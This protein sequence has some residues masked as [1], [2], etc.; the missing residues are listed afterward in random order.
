MKMFFRSCGCFMYWPF[1][2]IWW[3]VA[4][5][6]FTPSA[7]ICGIQ[8]EVERLRL[9]LSQMQDG[10]LIN[11]REAAAAAASG[12]MNKIYCLNDRC[13]QQMMLHCHQHHA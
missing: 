9:G 10:R 7:S 13:L 11:G 8:F 5:N 6:E 1:C 2:C 4:T 12:L 3:S